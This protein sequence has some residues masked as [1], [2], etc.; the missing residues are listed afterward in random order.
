MN[1]RHG[2]S[3]LA[4]L[5]LS[6]LATLAHAQDPKFEYGKKEEVKVVEWK[7]DAQ[8]GLVLTSG[9][10][11]TT[12]FSAGA[13]ASRKAGDNKFGAELV[14]AYGKTDLRI[15]QDRDA[16]GSE[17]AGTIEAD[18]I[19]TAESTA[20][21]NYMG[22]LRYDRFLTDRNS[23]F[24]TARAGADKAAGKDLI[25]GGQ[26]GYSRLVIKTGMHEIAGEFG[27]DFSYESYTAAD[28]D[29]VSIHSARIFLGYTGALSDATGLTGAFELLTNVNEEKD[30]VKDEMG[31]KGV[32]AFEDNRITAKIGLNTKL[33]SN[34]SFR[35]GFTAKY[36]QAP[37]PIAGGD[38]P[39]ASGFTPL[40]KELDTI[41]DVG[42]IVNLL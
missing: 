17:G 15:L 32:D 25:A 33:S 22:K 4:A 9:N 27:Y 14:I 23:I 18:E 13:N 29:P 31:G 5:G 7:A 21:N 30:A 10:S 20:P 40:S 16:P 34:V 12:I 6:S 1:A 8:A 35:F 24:V 26:V 3:L 37:A 38:I 28:A 2:L 19:T 41:T 11:H 39:F 36:D 42:L